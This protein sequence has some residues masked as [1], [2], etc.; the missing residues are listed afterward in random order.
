M[1]SD[2]AVFIIVT[3]GLILLLTGFIILILLLYK[4]HQSRSQRDLEMQKN[5]YEKKLLGTQLEMQE[6][7]M[8]HISREI[9]DNISSLLSMA[10]L[11]L[12][13]IRWY[14]A[15]E[16]QQKVS[17]SVDYVTRAIEDLK[18]L[19]KTLNG[20]YINRE[21][22]IN[23]IEQELNYIRRLKL[24]DSTE[25]ELEGTPAFVNDKSEVIIFRIVQEALSNS[26][27]HARSAT[28]LLVKIQFT[29]GHLHIAVCDNGKSWKAPNGREGRKGGMGL[30]N[31][32]Q[33]TQMLKG[34]F[35]IG[36]T[37][38]QGTTVSLT[39]PIET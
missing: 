24:F 30:R 19:S 1:N 10:K 18:Y 2:I 8:K 27:K 14:D 32:E 25:L 13:D 12:K 5:D 37:P 34:Q 28:R 6:Q 4:R 20:E 21:G 31:M 36:H 11:N 23:I 35:H 38:L 16:E 22:L 15:G 7:T 3:T 26:I 39:I 9:H 29:T 17:S 33:R